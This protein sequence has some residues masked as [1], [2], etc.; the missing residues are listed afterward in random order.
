MKPRSD[1]GL[2]PFRG[3]RRKTMQTSDINNQPANTGHCLNEHTGSGK[4]LT[5]AL[6]GNLIE[7]C[8]LIQERA[9]IVAELQQVEQQLLSCNH[10]EALASLAQWCKTRNKTFATALIQ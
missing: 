9:K 3:K 10:P 7:V 2:F 1:A 4:F 8:Q 5:M 6:N